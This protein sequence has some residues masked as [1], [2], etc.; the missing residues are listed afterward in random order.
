MKKSLIILL[1]VICVQCFAQKPENFAQFRL[2]ETDTILIPVDSIIY[3]YNY[4]TVGIIDKGYV[5]LVNNKF[6]STYEKNYLDN[7]KQ[8]LD[9]NYHVIRVSY[10]SIQDRWLVNNLLYYI[11][12]FS[13][14]VI[15][16][17]WCCKSSRANIKRM[18]TNH[19][20]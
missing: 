9:T 12:I 3:T 5:Q 8:K 6:K 20:T 10:R 19:S 2:L 14:L 18:I 11:P 1:S 13:Y 4:N 7:I 15:R 17:G 16:R